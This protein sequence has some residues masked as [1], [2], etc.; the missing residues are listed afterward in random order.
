MKQRIILLLFGIVLLGGMAM[1]SIKLRNTAQ[2]PDAIP[3]VGGEPVTTGETLVLG[4][5]PF[6]QQADPAWANMPVGGSGETMSA[7]GCTLS[8]IAMGLSGLGHTLTPGEVCETLKK[9]AGFTKNG[10]VI[11]GKV[12]R[13]TDGAVEVVTV[14]TSYARLDRELSE[15]RPVIVKVLLGGVIQHWVLVVG[16]EEQEYIALDP[17]NKAKQPVLLSSLSD[18]IYAL[19]VFKVR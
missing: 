4:K 8:S 10:Y 19:R 15:N 17:L 11:W 14:D 2:Y 16:K 7:V 13:L 6:Y 12:A 9:N 3:T 1:I 5:Y 18:K